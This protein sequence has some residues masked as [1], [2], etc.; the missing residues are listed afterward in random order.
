[1]DPISSRTEEDC[2]GECV[3]GYRLQDGARGSACKV[4]IAW[5]AGCVHGVNQDVAS[6]TGNNQ[7]KK[8]DPGYTLDDTKCVLTHADCSPSKWFIKIHSP[9]TFQGAHVLNLRE[10]EAFD[11]SGNLLQLVEPAVSGVEE[12]G[13]PR[14]RDGGYCIDGIKSVPA[15]RDNEMCHTATGTGDSDTYIR[16]RYNDPTV[17]DGATTRIAK[18]VVNNR[19]GAAGKR[20]KGATI[21]ITADAAGLEVVWSRKFATDDSVI[22]FDVVQADFSAA[23]KNNPLYGHHCATCSEPK[24]RTAHNQCSRCD[25][26]FG[27]NPNDTNQCKECTP[28]G[29]HFVGVDGVCYRITTTSTSTTTTTTSTTS[30]TTTA[31]TATTSSTTTVVL[32]DTQGLSTAADTS[33]EF[34]ANVAGSDS[35]GGVTNANTSSAPLAGSNSSTGALLPPTKRSNGTW[36]AVL[37]CL[38]CVL[39]VAGIVLYKKRAAVDEEVRLRGDDTELQERMSVSIP[40]A[41][42]PLRNKAARNDRNGAAEDAYTY[43]NES[44]L[45]ESHL[46]DGATASNRPRAA[47]TASNTFVRENPRYTAGYSTSPPKSSNVPSNVDNTVVYAVP[48]DETNGDSTDELYLQPVANNPMYVGVEGHDYATPDTGADVGDGVYVDDGYYTKDG[49]GDSGGGGGGGVGASASATLL[50]P[51][52]GRLKTGDG[53]K[54]V[55]EDD[56]AAADTTYLEPS[57]EQ[58]QV[59]DDQQSTGC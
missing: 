34:D 36:I 14:G 52:R 23:L 2:C 11:A 10:V 37:I 6:R 1:M 28:A 19:N 8:C 17:A 39:L 56:A 18:I 54:P 47:S 12:G 42:N 25:N 58:P 53:G 16:F 3:G 40:M 57:L 43:N 29:G 27:L 5:D 45:A 41:E 38:V 26:G 49:V 33:V 4:C 9:K 46:N 13:V 50:P 7:C 32:D 22:A 30:P 35:G 31:T 15:D 44:S 20:I 21:D 51:M 59:Y 24:D 48:M 55:I